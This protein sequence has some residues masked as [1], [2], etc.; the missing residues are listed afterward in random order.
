ML[1]WCWFVPS[2]HPVAF[3]RLKIA[4]VLGLWALFVFG[5]QFLPRAPGQPGDVASFNSWSHDTLLPYLNANLP[6]YLPRTIG[7]CSNTTAKQLPCTGTSPVVHVRQPDLKLDVIWLSDLDSITVNHVSITRLRPMTLN[8]PGQF[9]LNI[10]LNMNLSASLQGTACKLDMC[11]S[12]DQVVDWGVWQANFTISAACAQSAGSFRRLQMTALHFSPM[13]VHLL[14]GWF[15]FSVDVS[16]LLIPVVN[17]S[18]ASYVNGTAKLPL[19][20]DTLL[21]F[22]NDVVEANQFSDAS[23]CPRE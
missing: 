22:L 21:Q 20:S 23:A 15:S 3:S 6:H 2:R 18:L 10:T 11:A 1:R 7:V 5:L 19:F 4:A 8:E 14:V 12:L 9:A 17:E 16:D 13:P